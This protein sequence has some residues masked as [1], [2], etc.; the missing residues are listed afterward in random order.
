[1][2]KTFSMKYVLTMLF[3]GWSLLLFCSCSGQVKQVPTQIQSA[4]TIKNSFVLVKEV[5]FFLDSNHR[6]QLN[7]GT[8]WDFVD[9]ITQGDV[10]KTKDQTLTVKATNIFDAYI[11]ISSNKLVG[12]YLPTEK[13]FSP[14]EDS[15]VLEIREIKPN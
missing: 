13:T 9:T 4:P 11:V 7:S 6:R 10:F 3:M 12:F 1:M 2:I 15:Q 14:L 8:K 5:N